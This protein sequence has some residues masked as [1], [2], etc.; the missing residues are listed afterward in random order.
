[1]DA[2]VAAGITLAIYMCPGDTPLAISE[3]PQQLSL[4]QSFGY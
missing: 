4:A 2:A 1:L 3:K